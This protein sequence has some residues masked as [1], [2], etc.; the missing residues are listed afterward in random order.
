MRIHDEDFQI[1][2]DCVLGERFIDVE[3]KH[4]HECTQEW[5]NLEIAE[6]AWHQS[7]CID[8][9]WDV[10]ADRVLDK[11]ETWLLGGKYD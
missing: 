3:F 5:F 7:M 8:D 9:D 4:L 10:L 2:I 1:L 11:W 6:E